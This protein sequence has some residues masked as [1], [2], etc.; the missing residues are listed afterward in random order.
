MYQLHRFYIKT[1]KYVFFYI[2]SIQLMYKWTFNLSERLLQVKGD[3]TIILV[4]W[5][6]GKHTADV[7]GGWKRLRAVGDSVFDINRFDF[8]GLPPQSCLVH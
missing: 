4:I 7:E 8:W 2:L 1:K 6:A 3:K 5:Q